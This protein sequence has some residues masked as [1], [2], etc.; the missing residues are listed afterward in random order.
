[1]LGAELDEV[2]AA[3]ELVVAPPGGGGGVSDAEEMADSED[4][5]APRHPQQPPPP[6][7]PA[8][9]EETSPAEAPYGTARYDD[10]VL[11][12]APGTAPLRETSDASAVRDVLARQH[13]QLAFWR[14]AEDVL[15][16]RRFF[17]VT[18]LAGVRVERPEVFDASHTEVLRWVREGLVDGLRIDLSLIHI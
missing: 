3:G 11:P 8:A 15:N 7:E 12:L 2:I 1:M 5:T 14:R 9:D 18:S 6:Q 10:L 17:T 16:Y 13:W 4:A